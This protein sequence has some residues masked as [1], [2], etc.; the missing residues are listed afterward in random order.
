MDISN[1][2][3]VD[4]NTDLTKI[5]STKTIKYECQRCH[6]LVYGTLKAFKLKK[7]FLC[8]KCKT[9]K[10]CLLKYGSANMFA[11]E[12]L[13]ADRIAKNGGTWLSAECTQKMQNT[14]KDRYG[15]AHFTNREKSAKTFNEHKNDENFLKNIKAK[16]KRTCLSKYG[17]NHVA[18]TDGWKKKHKHTNLEKYGNEWFFQSEYGK[19]KIKH[20]MMSKYGVEHPL[21][22]NTFRTKAFS[23][24]VSAPERKLI[25]FL[26]NRKFEFI[27]QY[28]VN[29]KTFD[30]AI[31]KN[32]KLEIIVE[33]DGV[34]FHGLLEDAN[35]KHSRGELDHE[36]F[37]LV[38][39]GVKFI[40]CDDINIEKCFSEILKVFNVDYDSWISSIIASLPADF[41]YPTYSDERMKKDLEHLFKN[42]YNKNANLG[43]SIIHNYHKS[44][45]HAN[46]EHMMSPVAC[47]KDKNMLTKAV[48]NR[49]VY[50][51]SL[52]SQQIAK[53]FN[54]SGIAKTV[55]VFNASLAKYI[56]ETYLS[57]HD[58]VFDPFSGFSGRMLGVCAAGKRYIG[59]DMNE[60]H[61]KESNEIIQ[62]FNLNAQVTCDDVF[63]STGKYDCLFTCSPYHLKEQWNMKETDMSCDEWIDECVARFNCKQYAFVVDETVKYKD[64]IAM[65]ITNKSHFGS[66]DE[67]LI[68]L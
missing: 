33:I 38:P 50:A 64:N 35:G 40:V 25:E 66:N 31:F 27:H 36:R 43:L 30:F 46:R 51:S 49:I 1:A 37:R 6:N 41:P 5:P 42:T 61:V 48:K 45:W 9:E 21:Q 18:N 12:K 7:T 15:D 54:I 34:Y 60:I 56:V 20:S 57:A 24:N 55:S 8:K 63:H 67:Y 53:G 47:W 68:L 52:S 62:K 39:D 10:T 28:D 3:F 65:S 32:G 11:S 17:V 23:K 16:T 59:Q 26:Q 29:G 14:K 58:V 2:V 19:E 44:I 4:E 13:K 22:V